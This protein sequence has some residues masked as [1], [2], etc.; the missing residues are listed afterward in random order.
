MDKVININKNAQIVISKE[1]STNVVTITSEGLK[2][3]CPYC[4]QPD[5]YGDCDGSAGDID[6]L[7]SEE[8]MN[9]R[10]IAN[11]RVDGMESLILALVSEGYEPLDVKFQNA[12]LTTCDALAN[13]D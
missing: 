6:Y 8:Q 7:E 10:H 11:A 9:E 4:S 1:D 2:E 3:V 5:C 13:N 12:I